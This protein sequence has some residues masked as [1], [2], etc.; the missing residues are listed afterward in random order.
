[1]HAGSTLKHAL[2]GKAQYNWTVKK[3]SFVFRSLIPVT[4]PLCIIP[5]H[6]LILWLAQNRRPAGQGAQRPE[7][8]K[9]ILLQA[10]GA[11]ASSSPHGEFLHPRRSSFL[12][13]PVLPSIQASGSACERQD[14]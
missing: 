5:T 9:L 11:A 7:V 13:P 10:P 8:V 2:R 4:P 3:N 14:Y 6:R 12:F 1:M